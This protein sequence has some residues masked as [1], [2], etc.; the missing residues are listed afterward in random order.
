MTNIKPF[1]S[2]STLISELQ[3]KNDSTIHQ[4]A[5]ITEIKKV[6][7]VSQEKLEILMSG[8]SQ[9]MHKGLNLAETEE[10]QNDLKMI[11]SFV[12][13]KVNLV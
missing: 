9:E 13:G 7:Q 4:Q 11:P 5:V 2:G 6:F 8:V 10:Q 12:T 3:I 1:I